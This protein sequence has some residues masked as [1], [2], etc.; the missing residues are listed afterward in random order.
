[1]DTPQRTL[2]TLDPATPE[3]E[4][5]PVAVA[6][7]QLDPILHTH[8]CPI[9]QED[10]ECMEFCTTEMSFGEEL[11]GTPWECNAC[12]NAPAD[13]LDII[14]GKVEVGDVLRCDADALVY[15]IWHIDVPLL[16]AE[17]STVIGYPKATRTM[18]LAKDGSP[19]RRR[20]ADGQREPLWFRVTK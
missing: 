16:R 5:G 2:L 11:V 15:E 17:L 19:A 1:M 9:C 7:A 6:G 10:V 3:P 18:E 4:P 8:L 12:K 13:S 14:T 20:M